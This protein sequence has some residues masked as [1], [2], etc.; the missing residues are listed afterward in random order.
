MIIKTGTK[1]VKVSSL[2]SPENAKRSG[3]GKASRR[4]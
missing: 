4:S 3:E 2:V 1:F